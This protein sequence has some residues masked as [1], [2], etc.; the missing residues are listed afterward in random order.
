MAEQQVDTTPE[1]AI[2]EEDRNKA[3]LEAADKGLE[4]VIADRNKAPDAESST[5][6]AADQPP[7]EPPDTPPEPDKEPEQEQP[8]NDE[9][10]DVLTSMGLDAEGMTREFMESGDLGEE[11]RKALEAKG[12]TKDMVD[13]YLR[14]L[15]ASVSE[16]EQTALG[17]LPAGKET[18]DEM[19]KWVRSNDSGVTEAELAAYNRAVQ[20][21]DA[22][23]AK[24]AVDG[25]YARY[26]NANGVTG[27]RIE[28]DAGGP[29]VTGYQSWRQVQTAMADPRYQNDPAYRQEVERKLAVSEL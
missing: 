19:A 29:A 8:E 13:T 28:G 20:S 22:A 3:A 21:G 2:S 23:T 17:G 24:L 14:G 10:R 9:V 1:P 15:S 6:P 25:M 12:F 5:E 16:Y 11:S 18:F 7:P 27:R 4:G 26:V